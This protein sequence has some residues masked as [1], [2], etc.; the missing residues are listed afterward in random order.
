[1]ILI[2][3]TILIIFQSALKSASSA[4]RGGD[5]HSIKTKDQTNIIYLAVFEPDGKLNMKFILSRKK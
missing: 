1:M 4:Q 5:T 3:Y 2:V